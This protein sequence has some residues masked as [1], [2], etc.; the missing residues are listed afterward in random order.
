MP[1]KINSS[2]KSKAKQKP[3]AGSKN[4]KKAQG[5]KLK[6]ANNA[7]NFKKSLQVISQDVIEC[8]PVT[9]LMIK[10]NTERG[11]PAYIHAPLTLFP[12]PYPIDRYKE[13]IEYQKPMGQVLSGIVQDPE[14][15]IHS[16]LKDFSSKDEFMTHL[17]RISRVFNDQVKRGEP[18]Q[19]I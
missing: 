12:T 2:Q 4:I 7:K 6:K 16:L 1:K 5:S 14:Q 8:C 17:L 15:N 19:T 11:H 18:A 10:Q 13:A 3:R 9:G